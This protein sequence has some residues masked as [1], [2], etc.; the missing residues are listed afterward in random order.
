MTRPLLVRVLIGNAYVRE[1]F[2]V[3]SS[4]RCGRSARIV[5]PRRLRSRP[6]LLRLPRKPI[7][8]LER[9]NGRL[10]RL[11]CLPGEQVAR[12]ELYVRGCGGDV[13]SKRRLSRARSN[14]ALAERLARSPNGC[15]GGERRKFRDAGGN[16]CKT[17]IRRLPRIPASRQRARWRERQLRSAIAHSSARAP[18]AHVR[19]DL[20]STVPL[21]TK[22]VWFNCLTFLTART[23]L[24][25]S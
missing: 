21:E 23:I 1:G 5:S 14:A 9:G 11:W 17:R 8:S 25:L 22:R 24:R 20:A 4:L 15:L 6:E 3:S 2:R 18:Y 13:S 7:G 10:R 12:P 19:R 16:L